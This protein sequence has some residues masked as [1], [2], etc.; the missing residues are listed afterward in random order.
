MGCAA[1]RIISRTSAKCSSR[2][3]SSCKSQKREISSTGFGVASPVLELMQRG[4][5]QAQMCPL[6]MRKS[7]TPIF[8]HVFGRSFQK[9]QKSSPKVAKNRVQVD[10]SFGHLFDYSA[11][12]FENRKSD[13]EITHRQEVM[14][15]V[16]MFPTNFRK[17]RNTQ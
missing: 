6:Q 11:I 3:P 2:Y 14:K 13:L 17:I 15:P 7:Q 12:C 9:F 1:A 8:L 10:H 5:T 4:D 16:L